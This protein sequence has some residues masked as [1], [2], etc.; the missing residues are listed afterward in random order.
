MPQKKNFSSIPISLDFAAEGV[1]TVEVSRVMVLGWKRNKNVASG[2]SIGKER[3]V[4]N[5]YFLG[6]HA[7]PP[8][9]GE[10]PG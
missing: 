9:L 8:N 2:P 5:Y 1:G 10:K 3:S 7:I 4:H 6:A